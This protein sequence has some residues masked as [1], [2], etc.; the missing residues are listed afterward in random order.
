MKTI[1][2]YP[3]AITDMQT[4]LMPK[5]AKVLTAQLQKG[6]LMLWAMVDTDPILPKDARLFFIYGTGHPVADTDTQRYLTTFQLSDGA[7]VFHL[8]EDTLHD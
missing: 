8:F 2:K 1:Y 3:L 4:I 5:G 6:E 7:L